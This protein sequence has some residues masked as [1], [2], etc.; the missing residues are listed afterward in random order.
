[1]PPRRSS[2]RPTRRQVRLQ[3]P[4]ESS[5]FSGSRPSRPV[6]RCLFGRPD[7]EENRRW[8]DQCLSEVYNSMEAKW[9][10]ITP[11]FRKE[12]PTRNGARQPDYYLGRRK[13]PTTPRKSMDLDQSDAVGFPAGT[14]PPGKEI[15]SV[16]S[17]EMDSVR[18]SEDISFVKEETPRKKPLLDHNEVKED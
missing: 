4:I 12:T 16:L 7:H 3:S 15:S 17:P 6:N 1:M 11:I 5:L 13:L 2:Q 14:P 9:E 8:L 18:F 10:I